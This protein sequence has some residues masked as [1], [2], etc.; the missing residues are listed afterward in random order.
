MKHLSKIFMLL[1]FISAGTSMI[2]NIIKNESWSW[3]AITMLWILVAYTN[4]KLCDRYRNLIDK[5]TK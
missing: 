5:L 3:Q 1:A 4:E 2:D